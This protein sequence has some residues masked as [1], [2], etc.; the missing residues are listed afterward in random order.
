MRAGLCTKVTTVVSENVPQTGAVVRGMVPATVT[1]TVRQE[2]ITISV[3]Q[4]VGTDT[5]TLSVTTSLVPSL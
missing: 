5:S 1:G 2:D 3:S 4:T